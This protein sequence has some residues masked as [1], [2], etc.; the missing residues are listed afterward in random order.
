MSR[1]E[2]LW[3]TVQTPESQ[4]LTSSVMSRF[5]QLKS[6]R[7]LIEPIWK[8]I[9]DYVYPRRSGWNFE[10][11]ARVEAGDL[12][13][14]GAA[15]AA[16]NK[17]ADG[18]FGW[19][20]SPSIDWLEILPTNRKL[21]SNREV[22]AHC[23][24]LK[25]YLYEVFSRSN[26]YDAMAED[27]SDCSALGTSVLYVDEAKELGRPVYTPLH[28]REVYISE[29][30]YGE[31]D[32]L[33]RDFE[34]TNRQL[35]EIFGDK[36]EPKL[37]DQ[38]RSA[39]DKSCRILNAIYPR[40][41]GQGDD[42]YTPKED[43]PY[44]SVYILENPGIGASRPAGGSLLENGGIDYRK[45]E[46]WRFRK[47]S[48]QVYGMS[49][50]MDAIFDIKMIN[51]M[52]KT[53]ADVAQLAA[54]P[55]VQAPESMRGE[56]RIAPGAKNFG[57]SS[58][59]KVEPILTTLSYPFA[60]DSINR[61]EAIIR[62]HCKTD[63]FMTISQIQGSSRE[64]TKAEIN[65]IKSE[66]AAILG[67]IIGRAQSERLDPV[68]RLTIANEA[69]AGRLPKA[70]PGLAGLDIQLKLRFVGPL[71]QSQRKYLRLEGI[72]TGLAQALQFSEVDPDIVCDFKMPETAR[73]I[74]I[75]SGF[76]QEFLED[77]ATAKRKRQERQAAR[78][79]AAEA[80]L[81]N[82]AMAA[83]A[84]GGKAPE[85]GSLLAKKLLGE[86]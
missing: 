45:F 79:R 25:M 78:T 54:R 14:D 32:T 30:R 46:A 27:I 19:L 65:A 2:R 83:A 3:L 9:T 52:S 61:R 38:A 26:F 47:A 67:P 85:P 37:F 40:M 5:Q 6:E 64:R 29:N 77:P 20:V 74:A 22:M 39:L 82:Q 66:S 42:L 44:A 24:E 55:P 68:T 34:L 59:G 76:P 73:E 33:F 70:P 12:I 81:Q 1:D 71:A 58:D 8:E 16:H 53:M 80:E 41:N 36:L 35:L 72:S 48:N 11:D 23:Q 18:I 86:A 75:A 50:I 84:S 57:S 69:A 62:E 28:L 63:F 7:E 49:P 21:E 15:I 60:I 51:L 31:V 10:S 4:K 13:F 17:L 43:K 56:L